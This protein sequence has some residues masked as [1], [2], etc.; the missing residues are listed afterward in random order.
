MHLH[1]SRTIRILGSV[2]ELNVEFISFYPCWCSGGC[3]FLLAY[4]H[5]LP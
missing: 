4:V 1:R 5:E 3:G 2:I